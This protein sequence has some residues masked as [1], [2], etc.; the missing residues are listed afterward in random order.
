M[1][2]KLLEGS[3]CR[4]AQ[5]YCPGTYTNPFASMQLSAWDAGYKPYHARGAGP[6]ASGVASRRRSSFCEARV[7]FRLHDRHALED[8]ESISQVW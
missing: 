6:R 1:G 3:Y 4:L 5:D 2:P 8:L 7:V